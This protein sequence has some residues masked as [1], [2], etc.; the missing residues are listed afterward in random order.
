MTDIEA[1]RRSIEEMRAMMLASGIYLY[2]FI[3]LWYTEALSKLPSEAEHEKVS[4]AVNTTLGHLRN[5]QTTETEARTLRDAADKSIRDH[6]T[7]KS[8][9]RLP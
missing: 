5:N 2:S 1:Q 3:E 8:I 4:E 6:S 9:G 7:A